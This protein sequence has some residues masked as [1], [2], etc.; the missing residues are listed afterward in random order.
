MADEGRSEMQNRLQ[1]GDLRKQAATRNDIQLRPSLAILSAALRNREG[2][3]MMN[4]IV[5]QLSPEAKDY[6]RGLDRR[7]ERRTQFWVWLNDA[8]QFEVGPEELEEFFASDRITP[9]ERQRLLDL[10]RRK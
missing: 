2:D 1:P 10:P 4:Q 3:A 8:L 9:D 7:P 5:A 6:W